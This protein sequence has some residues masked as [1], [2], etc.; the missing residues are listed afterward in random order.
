M[1]V[2][3]VTLERDPLTSDARQS[4]TLDSMRSRKP[5]AGH[6]ARSLSTRAPLRGPVGERDPHEQLE[7]E[8]AAADELSWHG[9]SSPCP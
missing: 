9:G 8:L 2:T 1:A 7:L 4:R 6:A 5:H 3:T